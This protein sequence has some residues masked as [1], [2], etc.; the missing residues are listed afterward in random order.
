MGFWLGIL[1]M[2]GVASLGGAVTALRG[3]RSTDEELIRMANLIGT[4]N[5][6]TARRVCWVAVIVLG[7][8]G[9][10][11]LGA[12]AGFLLWALWGLIG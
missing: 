6:R 11:I 4:R 3:V 12:G 7:V 9:V 1:M 5:P 10:A 8:A 2:V